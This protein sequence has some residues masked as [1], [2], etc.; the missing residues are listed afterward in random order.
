ML[1]SKTPDVQLEAEDI[2]FVPNS[3]AKK[4]GVRTS[5]EAIIQTATGVTMYGVRP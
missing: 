1:T 4:A 5:V 2:V 3:T